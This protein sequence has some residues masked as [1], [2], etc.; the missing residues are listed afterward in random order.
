VLRALLTPGAHPQSLRRL[1]LVAEDESVPWRVRLHDR[2]TV[3]YR[4]HIA[5]AR[6]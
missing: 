5:A 2:S 1:A 3:E 4:L 6:A